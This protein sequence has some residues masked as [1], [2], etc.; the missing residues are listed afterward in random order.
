MR[1]TSPFLW[2][3]LGILGAAMALLL[4]RHE[5]GSVLGVE[6]GAF[7]QG[8]VLVALAIYLSLGLFNRASV[9]RTARYAAIWAVLL[10]VVLAGYTYRDQLEGVA[11]RFAAGIVPEETV[12]EPDGKGGQVVVNRRRGTHY[13]LTAHL[14]QAPIEMMVDTG[15]SIVTLTPEDARLAGISTTNLRYNVQVQTANGTALAAPVILDRLAVGTIE[16]RRVSALVTQPGQ[17]DTS[18]LGLNFL[19]SLGS[20]TFTRNSLVLTP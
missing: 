19:N 10:A 3:L 20:Y 16:R 11:R 6:S 1:R 4:L 14:N 9:G 2:L 12:V 15:A 18:L 7:A 8:A 13:L 17:L 5:S